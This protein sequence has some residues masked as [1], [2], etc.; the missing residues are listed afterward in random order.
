MRKQGTGPISPVASLSLF[1]FT[2]LFLAGCT[3]ASYRA[4]KV[5]EEIAS[6]AEKEY[7]IRQCDVRING[8]TLGV[9]LPLDQLFAMDFKEAILSGQVTDMEQ[10]FQPTEKAID[11]IEDMLFSMSRVM[12]S[13][14]KKIDFYY[15]QAA[16]TEKTGMEMMFLGASDDVK[17]VRFWDIPRSEYRKRLI[18]EIQLNRPILWHRPVRKFFADLNTMTRQELKPRYFKGQ[19]DVKWMKEFYFEDATGYPLERA[20]AS[21]EILDIRS[22]VLQDRQVVVYAKTRVTPK[23]AKIPPE[24]PEYLFHVSVDGE[25]EK[26]TRIIPMAMMASAFDDPSFPMNRDMILKS[27]D[28]WDTEFNVPDMTTGEFLALQLTRRIQMLIGQDE[29]IYNT[30]S[31]VKVMLKYE[32]SKPCHYSLYMTAPSKDIRQKVYSATGGINADVIYLW[33][34]A[35][36]EFADVLHGYGYK[37]WDYLMFFLSQTKSYSWRASREDL[38]LF[39]RK[40]K[41]LQDTLVLTTSRDTAA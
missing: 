40:K 24:T 14:D 11:R 16:D 27:L 13:T 31:G 6:I 39:R 25:K 22:L 26:I 18:Y 28:R 21:W 41:S 1:L 7:G 4:E 5:K 32:P 20:Q 30:F 9:F 23:G 29:R 3:P 38:E 17:K 34:L 8:T 37:D 19:E 15:L 33:E 12:L 2:V 10:L 36:R 35:A